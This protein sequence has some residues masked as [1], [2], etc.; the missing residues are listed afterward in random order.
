MPAPVDDALYIC[1]ACDGEFPASRM[2]KSHK[3]GALIIYGACLGCTNARKRAR[4]RDERSENGRLIEEVNAPDPSPCRLLADLLRED[5]DRWHF[6]FEQAWTEDLRFVLERIANPHQRTSWR[7][8]LTSTRDAWA[9]AWANEPGPGS[10]LTPT[11]A[12]HE[13]PSE[14]EPVLLVA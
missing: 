12:A 10:Q 1:R 11:L 9:A 8:V 6:D 7:E 13:P 4:E 14:R 2:A 5:R 3:R